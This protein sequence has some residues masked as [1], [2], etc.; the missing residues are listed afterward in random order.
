MLLLCDLTLKK[1]NKKI[2][3]RFSFVKKRNNLEIVL[4][5][6][7]PHICANTKNCKG[8]ASYITLLGG[9]I[10]LEASLIMPVIML[11]F[12]AILQFMV[13][14]DV[15]LSVQYSL[16]QQAMKTAGYSYLADTVEYYFF[17]DLDTEDYSEL[18][19][20]A[21]NGITELVIKQ[22]MVND[23]GDDF[24]DL[25]W[26]A[27]GKDGMYV[28]I[29]PWIEEGVI[30]VI[31]YY[32]LMPVFNVFG[33]DAIPMTARVRY[34]KWT[35]ITKAVNTEA[36]NVAESDVVYITKSGTV[37]HTYRDCTYIRVSLSSSK[38]SQV[39]SLRNAAGSKYYKCSTCCNQLT[40]DTTVYVSKYGERYHQCQT[41]SKIYHNVTA[42]S[43]EE[44]GGRGL[45][46]KCKKREKQN[47]N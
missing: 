16:Y 28:I 5:N 17:E 20:I 30:D 9:S 46:T 8:G 36:D 45:C 19:T 43:M 13:M 25:P 4:Q 22:L 31:I 10:T 23:L 39:D 1:Y 2:K 7:I 18:I 11:A 12:M 15:Q 27:N 42:V 44:I 14:L 34:G 41:C 21:E 47:D 26:I 33:L 40:A 38:Y 37:Y 35:G 6:G 29:T 32:E 3:D 24:F